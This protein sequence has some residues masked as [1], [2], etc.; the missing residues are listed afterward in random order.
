M[1][2]LDSEAKANASRCWPSPRGSNL[3]RLQK[4]CL[5]QVMRQWGHGAIWVW[6]EGGKDTLCCWEGQ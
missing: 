5:S 2:I 6:G 3:P 4:L 1:G